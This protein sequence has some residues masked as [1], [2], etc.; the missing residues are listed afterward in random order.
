MKDYK[1]KFRYASAS[2]R[3]SGEGTCKAE[4]QAAANVAAKNG[5]AGDL[6]TSPDNIVIVSMREYKP[7]KKKVAE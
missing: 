3:I 6:K 4:D 7:R 1:F 2:T 5:V